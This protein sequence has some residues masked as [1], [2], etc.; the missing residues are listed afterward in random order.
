MNFE[1]TYY[2]HLYKQGKQGFEEEMSQ[3]VSLELYSLKMALPGLCFR[4]L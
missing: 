4:S 3:E 2:S 1:C